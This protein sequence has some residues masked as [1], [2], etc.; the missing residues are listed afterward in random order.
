[1]AMQSHIIY[2]YGFN[3]PEID[4]QTMAAFIENHK[5]AIQH[6]ITDQSVTLDSTKL[7]HSDENIVIEYL[8]KLAALLPEDYLGFGF[9]DAL[10]RII[11]LVIEQETKLPVTYEHGQEDCM[12][13]E[14]IILPETMP[15]QCTSYHDLTEEK[16][17][18]IL[19]PYMQELKSETKPEP[20]AV[21]YYG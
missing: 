9:D 11:A 5:D 16:L 10:N 4:T 2:G 20:L 15:W 17:N 7:Q 6:I 21:E 14:C 12:G 19:L 8:E 13:G 18:E 1:M 3:L